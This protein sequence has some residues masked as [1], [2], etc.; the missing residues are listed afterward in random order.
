MKNEEEIS[1]SAEEADVA[2][3]FGED[4]MKIEEKRSNE[5]EG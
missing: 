1:K 5:G 2:V 4:E 3:A